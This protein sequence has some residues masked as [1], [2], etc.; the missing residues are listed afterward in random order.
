MAEKTVTQELIEDLEGNESENL[1]NEETEN[2]EQN[3]EIQKEES[4]SVITEELV[5]ELGLSNSF[6]GKPFKELGKTHIELLKAYSKQGNDI[7]DLRKQVEV[8]QE[9][10]TKKEEKKAIEETKDEF[11][12]MPDQFEDPQ[13]YKDWMK[14]FKKNLISEM[15]EE[16]LKEIAPSLKITNHLST[17]EMIGETIEL[18]QKNLPEGENAEEVLK[19]YISEN[20]EYFEELLSSGKGRTPQSLAKETIKDFKAKQFDKQNKLTDEEIKKIASDKAREQLVKKDVTTKS[21]NLNTNSREIKKTSLVSEIV[22]DMEQE[23]GE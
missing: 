9:Q 22:R 11:G 21:S 13:A 16:I 4:E 10:A 19:E 1:H 12:E 2:K 8:L 17:K 14:S 7:G 23:N 15:K 18:I 6:I 20:K 3:K 5:K